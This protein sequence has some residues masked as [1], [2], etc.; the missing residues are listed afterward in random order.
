MF[1]Q[2]LK[3]L[4]K[5]NQLTQ[6]DLAKKLGVSNGTVAMWETEKRTPD[7][8]MLNRLCILFDCRMDYLLG[9]TNDASPYP[10]YLRIEADVKHE[11]ELRRRAGRTEN[12]EIVEDTE[13]IE[14]WYG[15][16][17][18]DPNEIQDSYNR[19]DEYGKSAVRRLIED[20]LRRCKEQGT[21]K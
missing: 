1:A 3:E 5:K 9:Y 2:R 16:E 7:T 17:A 20:E 11:E 14:P 15:P 6:I 10:R 12:G 4:R 21:L 18:T 19:L 13:T 8:A